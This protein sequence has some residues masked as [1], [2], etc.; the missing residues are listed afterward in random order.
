MQKIASKHLMTVTTLMRSSA[1]KEEPTGMKD[2][3][4]LFHY[5]RL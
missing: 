1:K 4:V 2:L 3:P 5:I